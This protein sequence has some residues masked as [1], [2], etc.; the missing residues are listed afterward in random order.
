[1][2]VLYSDELQKDHYSPL[3]SRASC[4]VY[5]LFFI[6]IILPFALIVRTNNFWIVEFDYFEQPQVQSMNEIIVVVYTNTQTYTFAST[7]GLNDLLEL[8]RD[9]VP[10]KVSV[11]H[12]DLNSDGKNEEIHI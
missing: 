1:M 2:A 5:S 9:Q 8:D 12:V 11:E 7:Q 10:S 3:F 6:S 4:M